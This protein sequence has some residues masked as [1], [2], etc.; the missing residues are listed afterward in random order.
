MES[1][2]HD[3]TLEEMAGE[4]QVIETKR[5]RLRLPKM[6][7]RDGVWS[8]AHHASDMT[9]G[10]SWDPPTSMEE[11]DKFTKESLEGWKRG[12]SLV[13][14]IEDKETH[15]FFGRVVIRKQEKKDDVWYIGYWI[16]PDHQGNGYI[17]EAAQA[18]VDAAFDHI[19]MNAIISSHAT[20]N[21]ISGRVL[22]KIGMR[23]TGGN[24][25]GFMKKGEY[26]S[27]EEYEL[28]YDEWKKQI[29]LRGAADRI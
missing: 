26:V 15:A 7:D 29:L 2:S 20:W 25:M 12:D 8:A 27:E 16:H 28:T 6:E 21:T 13:W 14:T 3:Q 24:P 9:K 5:L 18:A 1:Q 10:L 17:T 19:H 11:L 4:I 23:H 22:S